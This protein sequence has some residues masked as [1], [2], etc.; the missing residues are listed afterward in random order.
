MNLVQKMKEAIGGFS[1]VE[2]MVTL[3]IF[4]LITGITLTKQS[5]FNSTIRLT[6]LTYE[7]ALQIRQAQTYGVSVRE[8]GV[9][10]GNF[11]LGYG[12][13]FDA[14]SP[15][16]FSFFADDDGDRE[17][18]VGTEFIDELSI[19]GGNT[20]SRFCVLPQ[21][22]SELCS[23]LDEITELVVVFERP[24]PEALI[25][26]DIGSSYQRATIYVQEP[27]GR[28]KSVIVES[29]GQISVN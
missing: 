29:T 27:S 14:N 3:G 13:Y 17:F 25:E 4:I 11:D 8:F 28:E 23:N 6:N 19:L 24:K 7:I 26:T 22:G 9:G 5:D 1:I 16:T 2:L 18:D 21:G 20:I 10:S 15:T 12:V